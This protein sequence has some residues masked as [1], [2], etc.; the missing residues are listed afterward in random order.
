MNSSKHKTAWTIIVSA[1]VF[2][3]IATSLVAAELAT[4]SSS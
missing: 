2:A 4:P 1:C 3:S